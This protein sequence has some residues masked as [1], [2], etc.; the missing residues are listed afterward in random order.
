MELELR[1]RSLGGRLW[2]V[3]GLGPAATGG[4]AKAAVQAA[5]G[6]PHRQQR[7]FLA[8]GGPGPPGA[9]GPT[10]PGAPRAFPANL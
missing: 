4:C 1:V 10:G 5:T 7:L 2:R 3:D 6:V 8:S 9:L